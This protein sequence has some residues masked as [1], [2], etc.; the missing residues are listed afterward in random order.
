MVEWWDQAALRPEDRERMRAMDRAEWPPEPNDVPNPRA[1]KPPPERTWP[2]EQA[3]RTV[4]FRSH[5]GAVIAKE[6]HVLRQ[7]CHDDD[8]V[9][10]IMD[11][12]E[13]FRKAF[14]TRSGEIE[15]VAP[16]LVSRLIAGLA[17]TLF[18]LGRKSVRLRRPDSS[19]STPRPSPLI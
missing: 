3:H 15:G 8:E 7:F 1:S 11:N 18:F 19:P 5:A 9:A 6:E 13:N 17:W 2:A 12:W 4:L 10:V 16:D 14:W